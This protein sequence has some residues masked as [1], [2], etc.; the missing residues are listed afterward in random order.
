MLLRRDPLTEG[1]QL[2][3]RHCATC[4][5]YGEEFENKKPTASNLQDFG[6]KEWIGGLL[7]NP[8]SP[9]YFGHTKLRRMSNWVD[10]TR[11]KARKDGKE[12][13]LEKEFDVIALWLAS[14]PGRDSAAEKTPE[15]NRGLQA[16]EKRCLRCH[17]YKNEGGDST[18]PGP[19][20]TGY[21]DAEWV[22]L[23]LMSPSHNLRYGIRNRMPAF[24][25]LEGPMAE[26]DHLDIKH[27]RDQFQKELREDAPEADKKKREQEIA[28]ATKVIQLSDIERELIIRFVLKDYRV[29]FGGEPISGPAK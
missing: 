19:D 12:A 8:A 15:F 17:S 22:R 5:I 14:H 16:F 4:H 1:R 26:I 6:T 21:G 28:E 3:E 25:D 11:S 27:M 2:F 23:M 20:F 29:V 24:R 9:A 7:D 10:S 13:D 18:P